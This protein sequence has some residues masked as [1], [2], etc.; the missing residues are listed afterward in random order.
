MISEGN[1]PQRDPHKTHNKT[2]KNPLASAV[3]GKHFVSRSDKRTIRVWDAETVNPWS[4]LL[5]GLVSWA[6]TVASSTGAYR[7]RYR[8]QMYP[9]LECPHSSYAALKD[10][11][12][13]PHCQYP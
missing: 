11:Q 4:E 7:F 9:S 8:E 6:S 5:K 10:R 1:T 3:D 13:Y 2:I 12:E